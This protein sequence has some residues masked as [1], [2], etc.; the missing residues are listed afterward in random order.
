[1]TADELQAAI[2]RAEGKRAELEA[3][4]PSAKASAKILT[5][6]PKAAAEFRRQLR[7]GL[8]GDER[9]VLRAR[10]AL[11][12][13]F[14]GQIRLVTEPDGG[15]VAHWIG[16]ES[17]LGAV[18]QSVVFKGGPTDGSGGAL[19]LSNGGLVATRVWLL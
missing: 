17:P 5:M 1:M 13:H 15:I 3:R 4:Q 16:H 2:D 18:C 12:R 9:A 14:G 6:L 11:R 10:A 7:E 8:D 19:H